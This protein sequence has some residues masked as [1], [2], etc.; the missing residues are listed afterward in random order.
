MG[1]WKS[2]LLPDVK[3]LRKHPWAPDKA[4]RQGLLGRALEHT[5]GHKEL[6]GD[7]ALLL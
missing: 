1:G 4:R 6:Q 7:R 5:T 3:S 2:T